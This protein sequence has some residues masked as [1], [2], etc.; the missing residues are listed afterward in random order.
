MNDVTKQSETVEG[1]LAKLYRAGTK[2]R[3]AAMLAAEHVL[4]NKPDSLLVSQATAAHL[5]QTSRFTIWRCVKDGQLHPVKIRGATRYKVSEIEKL[6]A[7]EPA[8]AA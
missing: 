5:L 3:R 7:G 6:A 8:T 4:A 1:L 2:Q